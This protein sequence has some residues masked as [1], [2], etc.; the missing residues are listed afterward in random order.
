MRCATRLM[1]PAS[2]TDEPP[3]FCTTSATGASLLPV[4]AAGGQECTH[5]ACAPPAVCR[6]G[7]GG[8]LLGD[9]EQ[10]VRDH[11]MQRAQRR[12]AVR[13]P[14]ADV[15]VLPPPQGLQ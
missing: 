10:G 15:G 13:A 5:P 3:Y 7:S 6:P 9:V 14:M 12:P 2:A 11:G 8:G 4:M 1:P